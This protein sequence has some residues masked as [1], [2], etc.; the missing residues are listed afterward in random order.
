[1]LKRT[2]KLIKYD[3]RA[4]LKYWWIIALITVFSAGVCASCLRSASMLEKLL[5]SD[6]VYNNNVLL[7]TVIFGRFIATIGGYAALVIFGITLF[8]TVLLLSIRFYK[9]FFTDEGYLTFTLP[10]SRRELYFSKVV[11][12]MTVILA[13][14]AIMT[15]CGIVMYAFIKSDEIRELFF[16][17][18]GSSSG[19]SGGAKIE[20]WRILVNSLLFLL[21]SAACILGVIGTLFANLTL[22]HFCITFGSVIVKRGK[23]VA[24]VGC[25]YLVNKVYSFLRDCLTGAFYAIGI[26]ALVF[27]FEFGLTF[28]QL[29][30]G[31][32]PFV[33]MAGA[34]Y[35]TLGFLFYNV[36]QA[37]IDKKLN[38]A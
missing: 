30:L 32:L 25:W 34:I 22:T 26:T 33:V 18:S 8:A 27:I 11:T 17:S 24:S 31:W 10:V 28:T 20:V 3:F 16:E 14:V 9:H 7:F 13:Q 37:L 5:E 2:L 29:L 6:R 38:L 19:S 4:M 35:W 1:M 23:I 36:T 12:S 21:S 15:V